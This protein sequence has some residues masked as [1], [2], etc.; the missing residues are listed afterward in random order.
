MDFIERIAQKFLKE[1]KNQ[2]HRLT[3]VFPTR[4]AGLYFNHHLKLQLHGHQSIWA[5]QVFSINDYIIQ[6]SESIVPDPLDLI[7]NLYKIYEKN[8]KD[9]PKEFKD[10]YSWG[11]M[12][13]SD[14]S[15]IDKYLINAHQ[16]FK[17][18]KEF[19]QI[20]EFGG[21]ELRSNILKN[22][23]GF[24]ADLGAI[25][26]AFKQDLKK[27]NRAYEGMIYREVAENLDLSIKRGS[28]KSSEKIIF[29]GLNALTKAE[30]TIIQ[31]LVEGHNAEIFWDMDSYFVDDDNQEAGYFFRKNQKKFQLNTSHWT[32]NKLL[33]Q[34]KS[35]TIIGAQS[36][37]S[38]AKILGI[39][40]EKLRESVNEEEIAVVLPDETLLFPTLNSLPNTIEKVNITIGF[41]LQQTPVYTLINSIMEMQSRF[42][43][44]SSSTINPNKGF[45]YK[46]VQ[47]ILN[48]PYIKPIFLNE[49]NTLLSIL[50][51]ENIIYITEENLSHLSDPIKQIFSLP[52]DSIQIVNFY[53]GL[54]DMIRTFFAENDAALFSIDYEYIYFFYTLFSRLK[55]SLRDTGLSLDILTFHQL[56]VDIVTATRIPFTGEPLEG[57]Q[58]MGML[59]TQIL[60]FP[61]IFILSVNEKHL[62]PS[63]SQQTFIP[64]DVRKIVGLP[65][66][67]E[68]DAIAA[69]HFYRLLKNS[70][71]IFLV[72]LTESKGLVKSEKSRFIDQILIEYA[73]KNRKARISHQVVDFSFDAQKVKEITICKSDRIFEM[74][75]RKSFSPS[76]LLTYLSCS[77]K[78]YF[79]YILKLKEEEGMY[80]SPDHRIIGNII[81]DT[82]RTLYLP[83]CSQ[84]KVI[85]TQDIEGL[86]AKLDISLGAS[87]KKVLKNLDHKTGRNRIV[88]EVLSRFLNN[89]LK[90]ESEDLGFRV[91]MVE[92][93]INNV[94]FP[95]VLNNEEFTVKLE[96]TIDR[97]D[98]IRGI[99][100][101]ID[102][103]TGRVNTLDLKSMDQLQGE[104]IVNRK[105]VFQLFFYRYLLYVAKKIFSGDF[106]L[107]AYPIRSMRDGLK[108][109]KIND[110]ETITIP[111]LEK[112]KEILTSI[113]QNL[114]DITVPFSQA[115]DEKMCFHCAYVNIC[116]RGPLE[117]HD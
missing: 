48:H 47:K 35:I 117:R 42:F 105:E 86:K 57:L 56:F 96:G 74:L 3:F 32:E 108:L 59:E 1:Y 46:D 70:K 97:L 19:K 9:F 8:V 17:T 52:K 107:G 77:L 22:Y 72:Y 43:D 79:S 10:F 20:E 85:N 26:F 6:L 62:P 11:K 44:V 92:Q 14:F 50:K 73:Q 76:S 29:C 89:F 102:Y 24:W 110:S 18:L 104:K 37:I 36:K 100:R 25:Y 61:N 58:I 39:K 91:L 21:E 38:Q 75:L 51:K 49:I 103:K 13:I 55:E 54:L 81:H 12:I 99:Y 34:E 40:L 94:K 113:F 88:W 69:Y 71:N 41:P 60:D 115:E 4:R 80:E 67:K 45:Y 64:F 65:T 112:Y 66:Y 111:M 5:P 83:F 98:F 33:D 15:E 7:F 68:Q 78:F 2:I 95:F 82:L 28:N 63:K 30:E 114:F 84:D 93:K 87:F 27:R 31:Y 106:M 116:C 23:I 101:I 16:L 90:K 109:V 53:L